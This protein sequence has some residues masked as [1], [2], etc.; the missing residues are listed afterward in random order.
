MAF[1]TEDIA[2]EFAEAIDADNPHRRRIRY[3]TNYGE[4]PG[5]IHAP[6]RSLRWTPAFATDDDKLRQVLLTAALRYAHQHH[7][8]P[9]AELEFAFVQR[10]TQ[11][12]NIHQQILC[13]GRDSFH[14][15]RLTEHIAV[16]SNAGGYLALC[17]A[18]AYRA[19]RL[20]WHDKTIGEELGLSWEAVHTQLHKL[21]KIARELGFETYDRRFRHEA[22][23]R[24]MVLGLW[25]SRRSVPQIAEELGC[26]KAVVRHIL[27]T[28]NVF[29]RHR[30][31][32]EA[33]DEQIA[34]LYVS[35]LGVTAI[36][37]QLRCATQPV[38]AALERAGL[39]P[40][41]QGNY[42]RGSRNTRSGDVKCQSQTDSLLASS[43]GA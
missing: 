34:E 31:P 41:R 16:V 17:G 43:A 20:Q 5:R 29:H 36:A 24:D 9:P 23:S 8:T 18:C 4:L 14:W 10:L 13:E 3:K 38:T 11:E 39:R 28:E 42:F 1:Q 22:V 21:V 27:K 7:E 6:G 12:W 2:A 19:W 25:N 32:T 15:R 26:C 37:A 30:K 40:R 35:G 33:T